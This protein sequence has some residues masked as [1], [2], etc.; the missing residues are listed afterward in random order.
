MFTKKKNTITGLR[1]ETS[2]NCSGVLLNEHRIPVLPEKDYFVKNFRLDG[3]APKQ[4]IKAYFHEDATCVKRNQRN[5]WCSYLAKTAEKWYPVESVTE[6]LMNRIGQVLGLHMNDCRLVKAAGQIRFLSRYFR[7]EGQRL[8]HGAEI[9]GAYLEDMPLAEE[10]AK[11][12]KSAREL[13]TF[14]FV[15]AS[16]R[17]AYPNHAD[18]L[19]LQLVKMIVFDAVTGNDDR[20][21]YNWGILDSSK[22]TGKPPKFA[23]LYDSARG[24]FWNWSDDNLSA[25]LRHHYTGG[26]KIVKYID[27]AAPRISVEGNSD[28]N[29]FDLVAFLKNA[30]PAFAA[31][32]AEMTTEE[33]EA[34]VLKML[35]KEFCALFVRQRCEAITVILKERFN[36]IRRL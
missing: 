31:I 24:L 33:K 7:G 8:V 13:F 19:I 4:F 34:T 14:Q 28:V 29:H 6:Y 9:C 18:L 1:T 36:Q 15:E 22:K 20:H 5:S 16:I 17:S 2:I 30:K 23:P 21:F 10:I 35:Q 26:R 11:D 12:K 27:N 25:Q 32:V 3:D